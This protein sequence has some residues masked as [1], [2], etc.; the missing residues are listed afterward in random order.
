MNSNGTSLWPELWQALGETLQMAVAALA[1]GGLAGLVLGIALYVTRK[2]NILANRPVFL[3]LNVLVNI[4][5]PIPFIIFITAILPLTHSVTGASFGTEA[6]IFPMAIITVFGTSRIVEQNL[7]ALDP[8]VVEAARAVGAGRLRIISSIIIPEALG[9][10]ILGYTFLFVAIVD[11]SAMAGAVAGGGL[12]DFALQYGYQR[13]NHVVTWVTV[14]VIVV[15]VQAA[16]MVGNVLA[17]RVLR[18]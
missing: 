9:P 7:V 11:M 5:R 8:G 4:V 3:V 14:A 13:F 16:Q 2:G 18:R 12:G 10:L 1:I 17:R 15:V 6:V